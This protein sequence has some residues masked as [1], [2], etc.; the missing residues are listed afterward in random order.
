MSRS[1]VPAMIN[2]PLQNASFLLNTALSLECSS[3]G[4][5]TPEIF[6][7]KS[8]SKDIPRAKFSKGNQ[9]L[10]VNQTVLDDSG[11]YECN[12]SNRAGYDTSKAWVQITGKV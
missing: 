10:T 5:P 1:V 8:G 4:S 6:W 9:I 3:T 2:P 11:M 7:T 12:A